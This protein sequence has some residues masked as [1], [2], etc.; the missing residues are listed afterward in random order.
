MYKQRRSLELSQD[1]VRAMELMC[2]SIMIVDLSQPPWPVQ[3]VNEAGESQPS[4]SK[5]ELMDAATGV[6]SAFQVPGADEGRVR[7]ECGQAIE[8][9]QNFNLAVRSQKDGQLL[10]MQFRSA[11]N[12]T[13]DSAMPKIAVPAT[14][15]SAA[16]YKKGEPIY[17]YVTLPPD[18]KRTS[19]KTSIDL[20]QPLTIKAEPVGAFQDVKLGPMLGI[21]SF[22]RV[23]RA[24][25]NGQTTAVKIM[26]HEERADG[27]AILEAVLSAKLSHPNVVRTFKHLTRR[28]PMAQEAHMEANG[29]MLMETWMIMVGHSVSVVFSDPLC[30]LSNTCA[31]KHHDAGV[32]QQG[33]HF[34]RCRL[35][36]VPQAQLNV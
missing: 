7:E 18:E 24:E 4:L 13:I 23:F 9:Q 21:G 32:L 15:A 3:C 25:W 8:L 10:R 16:A 34:R 28:I 11:T 12:S 5:D 35:R 20:N 31:P 17:Y 1:N 14:A 33:H 36:R 27:G 2:N 22:G 6:W 19:S 26:E 30:H 29:P